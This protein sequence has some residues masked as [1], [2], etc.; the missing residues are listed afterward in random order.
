MKAA[1]RALGTL[2]AFVVAVAL[3][4]ALFI[5]G[6]VYGLPAY[7]Y[8]LG[9]FVIGILFVWCLAWIW[10]DLL[11]GLDQLSDER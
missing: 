7:L 11:T 2:V 8:V 5:C 6:V 10:E 1:L 4:F 3:S 9:Q